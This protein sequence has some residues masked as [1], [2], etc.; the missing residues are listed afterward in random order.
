M[1]HTTF[2]TTLTLIA[3][4]LSLS[5]LAFTPATT[6]VDGRSIPEIEWKT[7]LEKFQMDNDKF[8]GQRFTA[9]CPPTSK[10]AGTDKADVYS[11]SHSICHAG[12]QAGAIDKK[13]GLVTVQLNPSGA[14]H[15]G[16]ATKSA[17][18]SLSVVG[19][20]SAE[21]TDQIYRDH[22]R[23]IKW[24]TK[25][26]STGLAYKQLIGQRFTFDCPAA[27]SGLRPRRIVGTD[28]YA[29]KSLIC[30]AAVHAGA[31]TTEG[32]LVTVQMNPAQR[33]L[34]GSTQNGIES[35]DGTSGL[36]ALSFVANP[37]KP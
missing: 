6:E 10:K 28:L 17:G 11:S 3:L 13:G 16:K 27:P 8:L 30:P 5:T 33:K 37:V 4:S 36:S 9:M 29:F 2:P 32:G 25:F 7:T 22:V 20:A 19:G 15:A 24:D 1:V 12:L 26:T 14:M 23:K 35:K 21:A 18:R 31:M 34:V